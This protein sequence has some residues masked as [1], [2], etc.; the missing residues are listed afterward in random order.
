MGFCYRCHQEITT[1]GCGCVK[2]S[3]S[4]IDG[5]PYLKFKYGWV[6]PKCNY[7]WSPSVA[8]CLN[9][10]RDEITTSA[11]TSSTTFTDGGERDE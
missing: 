2:V 11:S 9:C 3:F 7:I 4:Q 10:N 8:G 1:A 6:C 5:S